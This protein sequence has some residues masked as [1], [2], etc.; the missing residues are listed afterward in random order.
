MT[1]KANGR[2]PQLGP[3]RVPVDL[4]R[5]GPAMRAL[6]SDRWRAAAVARFM[7]PVGGHWSGNAAACRAAGFGNEEGTTTPRSMSA[8]AYKVFHDPRM[9]AA[10]DELGKEFL[11]GGVPDALTVVHEIMSD[12]K[13][14]DRLKAAQVVIN[15]AHPV[16]TAHHVTVEHVDDRRMVDF[17]LKLATELGIEAQKLIGRIDGQLI[18]QGPKQ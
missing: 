2:Q 13:Q 4:K 18:E 10:L 8:T 1:A 11:R 14:K 15:Y 3:P 7:V 12:K 16:Q 17:A 6:P 5:L 9:L